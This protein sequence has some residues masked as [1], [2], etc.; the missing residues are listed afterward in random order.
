M[1]TKL[2]AFILFLAPVLAYVIQNGAPIPV[3]FFRWEYPVP[4]ALLVLSTLLAGVFLGLLLSHARRNKEKNKQKK[5][6]KTAKKMKKS[7]EKLKKQQAKQQKSE[8]QKTA[9]LPSEG[10]DENITRSDG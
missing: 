2:L 8:G 4:Q 7:E 9:D 10:S 5:A 6:E 3:R 1:K